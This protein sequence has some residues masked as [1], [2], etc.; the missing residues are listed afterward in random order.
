MAGSAGFGLPAQPRRMNFR[1]RGLGR[2]AG[3]RRPVQ[4]NS[5]DGRKD[6]PDCEPSQ[7]SLRQ[8]PSASFPDPGPLLVGS[9]HHRPSRGTLDLAFFR[10]GG[11]YRSD[12]VNSKPSK[13]WGRVPP[14]VGRPRSPAKGRDG[15]SAPC[16]SSTMSSGRLFLDRV[17]RQQSPSPL[18]RRPQNNTHSSEAGAKGD[19]STLPARG[20]FYFALT[21]T[22]NVVDIEGE[23]M[24]HY[25]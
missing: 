20:H 15:R 14:P 11:I 7:E 10:H 22:E 16:S 19:I 4:G 17:A 5:P 2:A 3:Q 1:C 25:Q 24:F 18:H 13:S 23:L 8:S 21:L 9:A 12:V 6:Y